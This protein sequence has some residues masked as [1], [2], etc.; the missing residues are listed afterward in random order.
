LVVVMSGRGVGGVS[1]VDDA[2][3]P[4]R[5]APPEIGDLRGH[6]DEYYDGP[7]EWRDLCAEAKVDHVVELWQRLGHRPPHTRLL[8]VGCGEGAVSARLRQ[9]G[10]EVVGSEL[11]GSGATAARG[12]GLPVV[13]GDGGRLPL[14]ADV[15]DLAVLSHVVEHLEHPRQ[16]LAEAAR[17]ARWVFV[18][19]P[20]E[21]TWRT[22]R[23]YRWNDLGHINTY[24]LT[25]V[26]HL[27]QST[28]LRVAEEL[29]ANYPRAESQFRLGAFKGAAH[30]LGR[31]LT[32]RAAPPLARRLFVYHAAFLCEAPT[33]ADG[34]TWTRRLAPV[35]GEPWSRR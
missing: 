15:V 18:E 34:P 1:F 35:H 5:T 9:A 24:S 4:A 19:V 14:G 25:L 22:P 28:G 13:L 7:S 12:R 31:D 23:D 20:L 33:R 11:S 17:V 8:E 30:W 10:F 2:P 32:L 21:Y 29:V 27:L 6:Y 3:R 26:R 16:V